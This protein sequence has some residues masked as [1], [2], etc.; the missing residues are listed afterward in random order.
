MGR[1][2]GISVRAWWQTPPATDVR[3][4]VLGILGAER[5]GSAPKAIARTKPIEAKARR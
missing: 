2:I 5:H 4:T 3:K 1:F